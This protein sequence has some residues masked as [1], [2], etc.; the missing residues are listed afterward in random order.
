MNTLQHSAKL[1][2]SNIQKITVFLCVLFILIGF[3]SS[4]DDRVLYEM[5]SFIKGEGANS[6][7]LFGYCG[8]G[9][10]TIWTVGAINKNDELK[11]ACPTSKPIISYLIL[12]SGI[13]INTPINKWFPRKDGFTLSDS[14]T[15]KM[16]ML[17]SS[18]IR[19]FAT[20]VQIGR[21]S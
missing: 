14:I 4:Q 13:D 2:I 16:L 7:L 15:V 12:K 10:I 17:N 21:A 3:K 18:G 5:N 6:G 1:S 11:V 20:L 9:K 8:D 19:D